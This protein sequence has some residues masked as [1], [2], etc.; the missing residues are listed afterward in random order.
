MF[1]K[2]SI[3][4]WQCEIYAFSCFKFITGLWPSSFFFTR[5]KL[6]TNSPFDGWTSLM[7]LFFNISFTS[8]FTSSY[9]SRLTIGWEGIFDWKGFEWNGILYPFTMSKILGSCVIFIQAPTK[10]F[11]LPA[12]GTSGI[13]FDKNNLFINGWTFLDFHWIGF[14]EFKCMLKK[15]CC[16]VVI[17]TISD[18]LSFRS[19]YDV[20]VVVVGYHY[21]FFF[22]PIFVRKNFCPSHFLGTCEGLNEKGFLCFIKISFVCFFDLIVSAIWFLN[23]FLNKYSSCFCRSD[24]F[25]FNIDL[26]WYWEFITLPNTFNLLWYVIALLLYPSKSFIDI[27]TA[28]S[29]AP[30]ALSRI[31][32]NF[33]RG[34]ITSTVFRW[35]FFKTFSFSTLFLSFCHSAL[36]F[37]LPIN[38]RIYLLIPVSFLTGKNRNLFPAAIVFTILYLNRSIPRIIFHY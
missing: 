10:C 37:L 29:S 31:F 20:A 30:F 6:L 26:T 22:D 7:A 24:A 38:Q 14:S 21:G 17:P 5:N 28:S 9:P 2:P 35:S 13:F 34:P 16:W 18:F 33:D 3:L 15:I 19:R 4:K 8:S 25:S 32:H 23:F 36:R 12:N 27:W 1:C 11:S